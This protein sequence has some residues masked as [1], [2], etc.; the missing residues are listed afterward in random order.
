V[1]VNGNRVGITVAR[2]KIGTP[3]WFQ[4]QADAAKNIGGTVTSNGLTARAL[5]RASKYGIL[6]DEAANRFEVDPNLTAAQDGGSVLQKTD[7][8]NGVNPVFFSLNGQFPTDSPDEWQVTELAIGHANFLRLRNATHLTIAGA[9]PEISGQ[10]EVM[11]V[12]Y[13]TFTLGGPDGSSGPVP[14]GVFG[15]KMRHDY[16]LLSTAGTEAW[17]YSQAVITQIEPEITQKLLWNYQGGTFGDDIAQKTEET[18]DLADYGL[19]FGVPYG[20]SMLVV[21][22][23]KRSEPVGDAEAVSDSSFTAE[24]VVTPLAGDVNGDGVV[25]LADLAKLA[26]NWLASR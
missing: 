25:N 14:H 26:E 10:S 12:C 9:A 11:S 6:F 21:D 1:Q 4:W 18:K 24:L 22:H 13:G 20:I 16:R 17:T 3:N 2:S 15:L 5:A 23:S 7:S 8:R 19:E